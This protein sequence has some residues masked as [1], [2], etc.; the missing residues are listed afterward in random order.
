MFGIL[1]TCSCKN[2]IAGKQLASITDNSTIMCD[3]VIE[4][5]DEENKTISKNFMKNAKFLY[6][7][8]I[9]INFIIDSCQYLLL[10]DK[11]WSKTKTL[12]TILHHK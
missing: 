6:F 3:D 2:R 11:I 10:F 5:Y 8:C 1:L 9:L 7:T 12:I 4:S